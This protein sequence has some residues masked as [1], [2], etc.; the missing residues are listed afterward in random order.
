MAEFFVAV[1]NDNSGLPSQWRVSAE[2]SSEEDLHQNGTHNGNT[3]MRVQD[4]DMDQDRGTIS[5]PDA[6][7]GKKSPGRVYRITRSKL[8][9]LHPFP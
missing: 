2:S 8:P 1:L 6:K 7:S 3:W 4:K 5:L 9:K